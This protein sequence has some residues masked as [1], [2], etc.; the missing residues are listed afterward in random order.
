[1]WCGICGALG[2]DFTLTKEF[3]AMGLDELS[4]EPS[5]ILKLRSTIA[6]C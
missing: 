6:E 2:S 5:L 1:M 3:V 4:V